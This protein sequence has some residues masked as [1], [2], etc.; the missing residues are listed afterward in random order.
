MHQAF[1]PE[2]GPL[3]DKSLVN[4]ERR[5]LMELYAGAMG[6]FKSPLSHRTVD[7]DDPTIAAEQLLLADLLHRM[8][9]GFEARDSQADQGSE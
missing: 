1:S 9:D 6:A 2:S 8:L 5:A 7:Y 3:A 4:G